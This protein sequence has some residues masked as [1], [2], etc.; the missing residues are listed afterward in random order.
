M[1]NDVE[2]RMQIMGE[3]EEA[4]G[5][6]P[7]VVVATV[8][9]G[10]EIGLTVGA[11]LLVHRDGSTLG[12][13]DGKDVDATVAAAG[14]EAYEAFPRV[15]AQTLWV[16]S[17]GGAVSRRSQSRPGDAQLLL[18]LFEA[19]ARLLIVGGG[20][21]G[22]SIARIGAIVGFSIAVLD[23]RP[24]FANPERFPMAE[25]VMCGDIAEELQGT[26]IDNTTYIVLVSRGH[27][28]DALALRHTVSRGPAYL[29]MI[30]SRRRTA[31]VLQQLRDEGYSGDDLAKVHT[32]IGLDI[33]A[34][35]PEEI[36]LAIL[37]EIVLLR[38]GGTG[39]MLSTIT[40]R[41]AAEAT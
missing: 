11:K 6:G 41:R 4:L 25:E 28:Q 14:V 8:V 27:M 32:P 38:K 3:I 21:V 39:R 29:G 24:E 18:E 31:T 17:E 40:S 33:N 34:E 12:S 35:T 23:D 15:P 7:S 37:A 19:P 22:L 30:G 2:T 13:I 9:T 26:R 1:T 20:H 5:G 36:A 16:R 10:G